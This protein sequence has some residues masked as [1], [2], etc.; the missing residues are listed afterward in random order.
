MST[1]IYQNRCLRHKDI[2]TNLRCGR[3]GDFIC[4]K[5]LAVSPVGSRCQKCVQ[6]G[7]PEMF[8][9]S[10]SELVMVLIASIMLVIFGGLFLSLICRLLWALPI[11]YQV[12]SIVTALVLALLGTATGETIRRVGKYKIDRRLKIISGATL[13][14]IYIV[15]SAIGDAIG[16]PFILFTN[17][18]SFIGVAIGIYLALNRIHP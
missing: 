13:F 11:G 1:E 7:Q 6:L 18:I 16:V 10:K 9:S 14:G 15:G 3:C 5:C 17:I 12:G 2:G 4:P 8:R